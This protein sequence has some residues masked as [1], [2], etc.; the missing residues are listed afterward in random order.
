MELLDETKS[1]CPTCLS[2]IPAKIVTEEYKVYME[3]FCKNHGF[4]RSLLWSDSGLYKRAL[5]FSRR[6]S[7]A[8]PHIDKTYR[9]CPYDCGL[10]P[11]HEQHTC[12]AIV[13]VT[14]SCNLICPVCLAGSS[15]ESRWEPTLDDIGEM[16][17]ELLSCE[18]GPTAI[19]FSGGEPTLR[20]DLSEIISMAKD[21]GFK[22][23]EIDTNGIKLA[24]DPQLARE[25]ADAGLSGI[26]LQ[27]DG[28][29]P[30][31][32]LKIRGADLTRVKERAL[33]NCI[34]A[35]LAVTLAVTVIKGVNDHCLWD[36]V[37]YS[38]SRKTI[39]VNFQPFTA[40][41]RYPKSVFNPLDRVTVS[42]IQ[43]LIERQS[44]G[45][46]KALDFIPVPCSDPRCSAL[47][48]A[49]Y[50]DDGKVEVINR[51]ADIE[52]LIDR[53]SLKNRFVDF[54]E[55]LNAIA[56]ELNTS[57]SLVLN[58]NPQAMGSPLRFLLEHLKPEGFFSIGCHFAQDVW[59][60]D[61]KR[62]VKCC[63]HELREKGNLIP[64]CLYNITSVNGK[65]LYRT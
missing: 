60:I 36:I 43:V 61:L 55:L 34:K 4:F 57:K 27:F 10:C 17:K 35:G 64:F 18:G 13:E 63:V 29:D 1:L 47:V 3:K 21:I 26:Y 23:M 41:G 65:K 24:K 37:R 53:Y 7:P 32:H 40:L 8:K 15:R 9:G 28:L 62:V 54:D 58:C 51:L 33:S 20:K 25:L 12:L 30:S 49:Y 39:G 22:F 19:Q 46:V 42:D 56:C 48:Y 44:K 5:R 14:D 38:I 45:A 59:T 6:G 2:I 16:L 52:H 11:S 50:K 31:V